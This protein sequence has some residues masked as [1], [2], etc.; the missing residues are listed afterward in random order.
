MPSVKYR[1]IVDLSA[2]EGF[3]VND[4][5]L[6]NLCSLQY[7]LVEQAARLVATAGIGALM[8]KIDHKS[9]YRH[10]PVH[11]ADQ[12]L[13]GIQWNDV[14]YIDRALPLS[15]CSAPKLFTAIA[16]GMAWALRCEGIYNCIYDFLFWGPPG[17]QQ[18]SLALERT[19]EVCARLGLPT[20]P[21]KTVE[22]TT[23][24]TFL[25]IE[26]DSISQ[27]LR[28]PPDK[29]SQLRAMP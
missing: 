25:G 1:L 26:I 17:S 9:A 22:P 29:L 20:A 19:I 10:I 2:P 14:T 6:P 24:L 12:H 27:E 18:C 16:D 28:L 11:P 13:L 5:I 7:V 3:S 21:N 15:L 4:G 23:C 8:A